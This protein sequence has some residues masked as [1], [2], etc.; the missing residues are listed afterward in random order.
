MG[1][2]CCSAV[3]SVV[4]CTKLAQR[5]E[6]PAL[7]DDLHQALSVMAADT[8]DRIGQSLRNTNRGAE[9]KRCNWGPDGADVPLH[10]SADSLLMQ[11]RWKMVSQSFVLPGAAP[12]TTH[13]C[14]LEMGQRNFEQMPRKFSDAPAGSA[15]AISLLRHRLQ[16]QIAAGFFFFFFFHFESRDFLTFRGA[17]RRYEST[18]VASVG[19]GSKR[20][21]L[22]AGNSHAIFKK[23]KKIAAA[24][25]ANRS[26]PAT[27]DFGQP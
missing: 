11:R 22:V 16:F 12:P 15:S 10:S 27:A 5:C 8:Q 3:V 13:F 1:D 6:G 2:I 23:K 4:L 26:E 14:A 25:S 21:V 19:P 18:H 20:S 7:T 24:T 17:R 9:V